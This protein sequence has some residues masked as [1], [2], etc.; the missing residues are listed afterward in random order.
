MQLK[1]K[2]TKLF[3]RPISY[4]IKGFNLSIE[5][6][7]PHQS[8]GENLFVVSYEH[9]NNVCLSVEDSLKSFEF[10]S[11][12]KKLETENS[13]FSLFSKIQKKV[14]FANAEMNCYVN[15]LNDFLKPREN[16]QELDSRLIMGL[17]HK[18][19]LGQKKLLSLK[20]INGMLKQLNEKQ[21]DLG[22]L[23]VRELQKMILNS[24]SRLETGNKIIDE[25]STELKLNKLL[26]RNFDVDESEQDLIFRKTTFLF[27]I[28]RPIFSVYEEILSKNPLV[29]SDFTMNIEDQTIFLDILSKILEKIE[30]VEELHPDTMLDG[31]TW[32]VDTYTY[33]RYQLNAEFTK[34]ILKIP[35]HY[36]DLPMTFS[37]SN[38]IHSSTGVA[39]FNL[40][41]GKTEDVSKVTSEKNNYL[42]DYF[43]VVRSKTATTSVNFPKKSVESLNYLQGIPFRISDRRLNLIKNNCLIFLMQ[44]LIGNS[45]FETSL[46]FGS[47]GENKIILLN[48]DEFVSKCKNILLVNSSKDIKILKIKYKKYIRLIIQF[49]F[50]IKLSDIYSRHSKSIFFK[51][52]ID[53]RGRI[54]YTGNF[55]SPQGNFLSDFLLSISDNCINDYA[56]P[57][58]HD[59][60][61][62]LIAYERTKIYEKI[63]LKDKDLNSLTINKLNL[64]IKG[65]EFFL[66]LKYL[67]EQNIK[68]KYREI[69]LDVSASGFQ[70]LSGLSGDL[71][72][73]LSTNFLS[74]ANSLINEKQDI[75]LDIRNRFILYLE[76][77]RKIENS[78]KNLDGVFICEKIIEIC[79]RKFVKYWAMLDIYSQKTITRVREILPKIK[80][81]AGDRS[82]F[83]FIDGGTS[84]NYLL[85]YQI[86]QEFPN[87]YRDFGASLCSNFIVKSIKKSNNK[88]PYLHIVSGD[89]NNHIKSLYYVGKFTKTMMSSWSFLRKRQR[90]TVPIES[91]IRD[92]R[93]VSRGCCPHFV[94]HLDSKICFFVINRCKEENIPLYVRHDC[95][96]SLTGYIPKI[97]LFYF[98]G[99]KKYILEEDP[100]RVYLEANSVVIDGST[101]ETLSLYKKKR[102]NILKKISNN[103]LVQ[104]PFILTE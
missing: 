70:I 61:K 99:F 2:F 81:K 12:E 24:F 68:L 92:K 73:L 26:D 13:Q 77:T 55:L 60:L 46:I 15:K 88:N 29:S 103:E 90:M 19:S 20:K 6:K 78:K 84:V 9:L 72:G 51:T 16:C 100:V 44:Y 80:E 27:D 53:R 49:L 40:T 36:N 65:K 85:V 4:G 43:V 89:D 8:K 94:H 56:L 62:K 45:A 37:P 76:E 63:S 1:T 23:I 10:N 39:T 69:G 66:A 75:Y 59:N 82:L 32:I 33:Y 3:S 31:R 74:Y 86:C 98:Q 58:V 97:S 18:R 25:S 22:I 17:D 14:Y 87:V 96:Y 93:L 67:E 48:E 57:E 52:C 34:S 95:Y 91:E 38:W 30:I 42:S 11:S 83:E 21:C 104:S 50:A 101:E 5:I 28:T 102:N 54:Y 35:F 64:L 79:D 41:L 47:F 7:S 71:D